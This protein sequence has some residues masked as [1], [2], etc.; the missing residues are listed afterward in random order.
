[1]GYVVYFGDGP[2]NDY[3]RGPDGALAVYHDPQEAKRVR[4]LFG[5]RVLQYNPTQH[6]KHIR[7]VK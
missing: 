5:G 2:N 4:S 6:G 1:M 3:L 7:E